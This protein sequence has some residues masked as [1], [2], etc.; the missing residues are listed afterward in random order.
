[1]LRRVLA[2]DVRDEIGDAVLT[3]ELTFQARLLKG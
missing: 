3:A 1:V 2:V